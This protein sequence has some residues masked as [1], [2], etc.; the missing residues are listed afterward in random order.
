MIVKVQ[1]PI[2]TN[3]PTPQMLVY[4]QDRRVEVMMPVSERMASELKEFPYKGFFQAYWAKGTA[5]ELVFG[6]RVPD[7]EW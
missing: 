5:N 1:L 2:S 7:A 3:E 6:K 4:T